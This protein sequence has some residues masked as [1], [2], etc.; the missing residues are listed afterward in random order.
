MVESLTSYIQRLAAAHAVETGTLVNCELLLRV[1]FAKGERSGQLP[2]KLPQYSFYIEAYRLN[3]IGDRA[4]LWVSALEE[5][6][7]VPRYTIASPVASSNK[8]CR[9]LFRQLLPLRCPCLP[10]SWVIAQMRRYAIDSRNSVVR[11]Q[12]RDELR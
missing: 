4:R 1:P 5:L 9:L 11:S 10:T 3:G 8:P 7:R 6:T 12:P 2:T